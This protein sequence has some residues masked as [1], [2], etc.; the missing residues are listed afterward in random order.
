[1]RKIRILRAILRRDTKRETAMIPPA[2]LRLL[3]S[4][5][6]GQPL[7]LAEGKLR[8]QDGGFG[9]EIDGKLPIL[10][11]QQAREGFRRAEQHE[12]FG[13]R[14][15]YVD[16]YQVDA[17]FFDYFEDFEDG[18]SRHEMRRLHE[19]IISEVPR[20]AGSILDV[21]CGQAWVAQYF[22]PRGV[23][24][25][26]MDIST[27][28]PLRALERYP[29]DNHYGVVA[30][31]YRLPFRPDSFDCIIACEIIEH[32][33]DPAEFMASLMR[34]L[35]PGGQLIITTPHNERIQ[36]S[37]CIHCNRPTPHHAHLHSFT[38]KKMQFLAPG[39]LVAA[40]RCYAFGNKALIKLKTHV[41]LKYLP[42]PLWRW[43]DRLANGLV[44]L[45]SRILFK[46]ERR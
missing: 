8:A 11:P 24:V 36:H 10:L 22:C 32:V 30:D 25:H 28:N 16:H 45:P 4:P 12:R 9:Y 2:Q 13:S 27:V 19:T 5:D 41:L 40:Q 29:Y 33:P 14:F 18:A 31:A 21:G 3:I 35:K 26:S 17:E 15:F 46:L 44:R 7:E 20:Q 42:F 43:L 37:L 1:M 39:E 23:A 34:V 38:I 6:D